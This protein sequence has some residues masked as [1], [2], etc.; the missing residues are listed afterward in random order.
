[1]ATLVPL[2]RSLRASIPT[3][4]RAVQ[5]PLLLNS[6]EHSSVQGTDSR[7]VPLLQTESPF[8]P[9]PRSTYTQTHV[10]TRSDHGVLTDLVP[11]YYWKLSFPSYLR[12]PPYAGHF[13]TMFFFRQTFRSWKRHWERRKLKIIFLIHHLY[14][15]F[16]RKSLKST[17]RLCTRN[18]EL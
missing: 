14:L 1:M 7:A 17:W 15:K 6:G 3:V 9:T 16:T 18:P 8:P 11:N 2:V 13:T 12:H 10:C 4:I 5:L